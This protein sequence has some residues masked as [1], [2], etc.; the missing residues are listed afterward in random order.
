MSSGLTDRAIFVEMQKEV[1][2]LVLTGDS[3]CQHPYCLSLDL[4]S[5]TLSVLLSRGVVERCPERGTYR[6]NESDL[7]SLIGALRDLPLRRPAVRC[8][9]ALPQVILPSVAVQAKL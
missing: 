2:K 1:E 5:T 6:V 8:V 3:C 9:D 7:A 4:Y